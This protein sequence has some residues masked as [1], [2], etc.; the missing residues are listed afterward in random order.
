M[1]FFLCC[2]L[3]RYLKEDYYITKTDIIGDIIVVYWLTGWLV[4]SYER[5]FE[6]QS[7]YYVHFQTNTYALKSTTK[8]LK[9][10]I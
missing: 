1:S 4:E 9:G 6:H 8:V 3:E 5:E 2:S 7:R 10:C